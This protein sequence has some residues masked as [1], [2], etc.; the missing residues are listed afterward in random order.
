MKSEGI[1][2]IAT[3]KK[4]YHDYEVVETFEAGIVL[5]GSEVKSIRRGSISLKEGYV[6][7]KNGE[8]I[9]TKCNVSPYSASSFFSHE[10]LRDRKLLMHKREIMRLQGKVQEKGLTI[11]PLKVYFKKGNIKIEIGLVRGK[12]QYDK[13]AEARKKTIER[14]IQTALKGYRH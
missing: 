10:P 4:A 13:R 5:Q 8:L 2:I 7:I 1:K 12:K 11:V 3:N 14:E 6:K 9:L